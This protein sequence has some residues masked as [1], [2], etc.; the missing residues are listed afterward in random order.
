MNP[1]QE[2]QI[3]M[4]RE[5]EEQEDVHSI[6]EIP[7]VHSIAVSLG[8]IDLLS[9]TAQNVFDQVLIEH[10]NSLVEYN[11]YHIVITETLRHKEDEDAQ[12]HEM[13]EL[14]IRL[15]DNR[16]GFSENN[17]TYTHVIGSPIR[18]KYQYVF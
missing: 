9:P 16:G 13:W 14:N 12:I 3:N 11:F 2:N 1:D 17:L 15:I 4:E 6:D 10:Y 8:K 18:N 5:M 7:I